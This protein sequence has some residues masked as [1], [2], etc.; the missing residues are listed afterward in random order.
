MVSEEIQDRIVAAV[1]ARQAEVIDFAQR[2]IQIES[3][4]GHEG[5]VQDFL[6][7]E[8]RRCGLAVDQFAPDLRR[9]GATRLSSR[10]RA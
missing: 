5:A 1:G 10:S 8:L 3:V 4:T 9:S 6:A 2:L 7:A